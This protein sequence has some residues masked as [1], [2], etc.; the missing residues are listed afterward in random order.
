MLKVGALLIHIS[1]GE[2][3]LHERQRGYVWA[4]A[5][6]RPYPQSRY[7]GHPVGH[8]LISHAYGPVPTKSGVSEAATGTR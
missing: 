6:A 7:R 5:K 1:R 8:F 2:L 3:K 4:R